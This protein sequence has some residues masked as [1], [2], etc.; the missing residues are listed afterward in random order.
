MFWNVIYFTLAV[1]GYIHEKTSV[2]KAIIL[3]LRG[4]FLIGEHY[5]SWHLWYLL[6]AIYGLLLVII[7]IRCKFTTKQWGY[8][9]C[10]ICALSVVMDWIVDGNYPLPSVLVI[11]KKIVSLTLASGRVLQG[12][13]FIPTGIL[14]ANKHLSQKSY[15]ILF[16]GSFAVNFVVESSLA[17]SL[18]LILSSIALFGLTLSVKLKDHGIYPIIRKLSTVMYL[19]HMYIW[20]FYYSIVYQEK[21][22]GLDSFVITTTICVI[23][24]AVYCYFD[25]DRYRAKKKR[26]YSLKCKFCWKNIKM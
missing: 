4:F 8:T 5:N 10:A 7:M 12:A 19:I 21:T 24:G 26:R 15:W 23:L 11:A 17:S 2:L 14:M 13:I 9:V 6:S 25:S 18:L 16:A 20:T 1:C 22:F 3:Y